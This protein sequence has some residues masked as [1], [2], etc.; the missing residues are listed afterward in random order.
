MHTIHNRI[1]H[2]NKQQGTLKYQC[3]YV[4]VRIYLP[5]IEYRDYVSI[6]DDGYKEMSKLK[7]SHIKVICPCKDETI[8]AF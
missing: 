4:S 2:K 6:Y 8:W 1:K 3:L 7:K 5:C